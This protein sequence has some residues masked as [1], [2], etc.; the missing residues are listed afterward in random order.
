MQDC[1]F[2]PTVLIRYWSLS[3]RT[4][5]HQSAQPIEPHKSGHF[6][7]YTGSDGQL[8]FESSSFIIS[9][10]FITNKPHEWSAISPSHVAWVTV[11]YSPR[12]LPPSPH[13]IAAGY[14]AH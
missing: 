4:I 7:D 1:L 13:I 3:P 6:I 9:Y 14:A 5:R 2:R 11:N 10:G 8:H 12:D